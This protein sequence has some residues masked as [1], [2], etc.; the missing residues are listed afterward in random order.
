MLGGRELTNGAQGRLAGMA[1]AA[2]QGQQVTASRGHGRRSLAGL[3]GQ[4]EE[5]V[6]GSQVDGGAVSQADVRQL[7]I[8]DRRVVGSSQAG[9]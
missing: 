1:E 7:G 9:S 8:K 5:P 3:E 2:V 6:R 4:P